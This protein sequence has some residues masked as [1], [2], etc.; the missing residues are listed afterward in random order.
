M[1][2][3]TAHVI[4]QCT[5]ATAPALVVRGAGLCCHLEY[6][7]NNP[8]FYQLDVFSQLII[9]LFVVVAARGIVGDLQSTHVQ[10]IIAWDTLL[11]PISLS[12]RRVIVNGP[13]DGR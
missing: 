13:S 1:S 8:T 3:V 10:V 11:S 6:N 12:C 7:L 2:D 9:V 5:V 4:W